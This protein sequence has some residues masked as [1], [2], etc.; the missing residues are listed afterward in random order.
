MFCHTLALTQV[1]GLPFLAGKRSSGRPARPRRTCFWLCVNRR[2]PARPAAVWGDRN[3]KGACPAPT[4]CSLSSLSPLMGQ[5][6]AHGEAEFIP[7]E[8]RDPD[9]WV[10]DRPLP[11]RFRTSKHSTQPCCFSLPGTEMIYFAFPRGKERPRDRNEAKP[12]GLDTLRYQFP[13]ATPAT[14]PPLQ[15]SNCRGRAVAPDHACA[16]A[17]EKAAFEGRSLSSARL[18]NGVE[19]SAICLK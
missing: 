14:G 5:G 19:M 8:S 16:R 7:Q 11:P 18:R 9:R 13:L 3:Q 4:T 15:T 17:V 10:R 6:A 2:A 12:Q 1:Q